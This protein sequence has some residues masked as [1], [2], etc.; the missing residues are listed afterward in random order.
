MAETW[1]RVWEGRTNF[2]RTRISEWLLFWKDF[3]FHGQNCWRPFVM[4]ATRFFGFPFLFPDFPY[5]YYVK[6]RIWPFPHKNPLFQKWKFLY[7][8]FFYSAH[9]F[10]CIPQTL[11]LKILVGRMH[12]PSSHLRFWGDRPP[13]SPLHVGLRPCSRTTYKCRLSFADHHVKLCH[14]KLPK[15]V[16]L[17][18]YILKK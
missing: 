10:A 3:H 12:G 17:C 15:L 4:S 7:D 6:C 16:A 18:L 13:S 14:G 11:L 8:T 5:L 2:S 9:T 1:R